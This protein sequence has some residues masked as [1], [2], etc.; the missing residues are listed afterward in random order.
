[1]KGV[2]I[3]WVVCSVLFYA[4]GIVVGAGVE[5]VGILSGFQA[6]VASVAVLEAGVNAAFLWYMDDGPGFQGGPPPEPAPP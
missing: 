2:F 5:Q 4:G 6:G 3:G 1:M